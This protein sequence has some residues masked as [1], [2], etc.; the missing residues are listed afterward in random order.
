[1]DVEHDQIASLMSER[2]EVESGMRRWLVGR[3]GRNEVVLGVSGIGKVNA[4]F[5]ATQLFNEFKPDALVSSGCAGGLGSEVSVGDV[6][7]GSEY[8]YHDVD[9]GFGA[10]PGQ[11]QGMPLFFPADP[12][13]LATAK[14]LRGSVDA[15]IH[16][17]LMVTGDQFI[18][19][20]A[21]ISPIRKLFPHA[22]ACEMESA[23]LAHVCR[24]VGVPFIS[25]RVISDTPGAAGHSMQFQDFWDNLANVSFNVTRAFLEAI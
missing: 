13:L 9:F 6:V 11:V 4:A 25:F 17:G 19:G 21:L 22:L 15:C 14:S 1:M 12:G 23:A 7:V 3:I 20:D 24:I 16:A 2:R 10:P 5:T 18:A 8:A